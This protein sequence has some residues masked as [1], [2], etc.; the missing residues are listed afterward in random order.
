MPPLK[1]HHL[2]Y[3]QS[4][5]IP[6]L[7]HELAL[8]N[9]PI[10]YEL[11]IHRRAPYFSP[12]ALVALHPM[13]AAPVL[14]DGPLILAESGAIIE[15]VLDTHAPS[16]TLKLR[17]N[18]PGYTNYLFW[19]HWANANLQPCIMRCVTLVRT[20]LPDSH[21]AKVGV[22]ERLHTALAFLDA[23]LREDGVEWLAGPEGGFSAAD[24]MMVFL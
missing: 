23:H 1:V 5:R 20:G 24:I 10:P 3:S 13:K 8:T 2:Q 6:W 21:P 19:F 12:P 4:E 16:S 22:V 14:E 9:Q 17:P 18:Q 11:I 7:L 15:Y